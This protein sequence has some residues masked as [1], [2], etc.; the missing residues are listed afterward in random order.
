M[1]VSSLNQI[2]SDFQLELCG[3]GWIWASL[4]G[5]CPFCGLDIE[6][7]PFCLA[8]FHPC[9]L[10]P[11]SPVFTL[12]ATPNP[13]LAREG[14]RLPAGTWVSL[15]RILLCKW[16]DSQETGWPS[17]EGNLSW[18]TFSVSLRS[19][20]CVREHQTESVSLLLR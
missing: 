2:L 7:L 9:F 15:S 18:R 1:V 17:A 11:P 13:R 20:S 14:S 10:R 8:V 6:K 12:R 3:V 19:H 16:A 4:K 5:L